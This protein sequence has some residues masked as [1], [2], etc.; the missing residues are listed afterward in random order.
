[1]KIYIQLL[2]SITCFCSLFFISNV[3]VYRE[4][5]SHYGVLLLNIMVLFLFILK[6]KIINISGYA[7]VFFGISIWLLAYSHFDFTQEY[8]KIWDIIGDN[9]LMMFSIL[10]MNI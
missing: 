8:Y 5:I 3:C 1:M 10:S 6:N 2:F 7:L 4:I 9:L